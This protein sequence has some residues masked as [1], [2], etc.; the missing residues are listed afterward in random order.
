[1]IG[2]GVKFG[3]TGQNTRAFAT[4]MQWQDLKVYTV[5]PRNL[6][7]RDPAM[8]PLPEWSAR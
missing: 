2:W 8:I 1:V 4:V 6:A 7:L 5:F 3:D